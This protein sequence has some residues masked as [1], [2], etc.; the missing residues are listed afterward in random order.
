MMQA[1]LSSDEA[2]G[3]LAKF[4]PNAMP[5]SSVHPLRMAVE[6]FWAP[7]PWLLE[8]A[9]V[10]ELALGSYPEAGIIAALLVFAVILDSVK[11]PLFSRLRIT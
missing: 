4:G 5:D 6:K 8:A 10:L 2:R 9:V 7:V 11:L 1:G 3:R